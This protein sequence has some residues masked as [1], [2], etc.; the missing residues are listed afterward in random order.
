ML[1]A[2]EA[3]GV[4]RYKSDYSRHAGQRARF[5]IAFNTKR[6]DDAVGGSPLSFASEG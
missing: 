3:R 5:Q 1:K 6:F 4:D 2:A